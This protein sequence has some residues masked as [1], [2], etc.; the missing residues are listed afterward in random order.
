[1]DA[2]DFKRVL[3]EG[4]ALQARL[5][6]LSPV[7]VGGTAAALHCGHRFSLDV[8]VVAAQLS[9]RFDEVAAQLAEWEGWRTNRLNPPVLILGEHGG[10]ELGVRQ[11]RRAVPLQTTRVSEL[12]VATAAET[13]RIK[14]FL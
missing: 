6:D 4:R 1:M 10:V 5:A 8:D 2:P 13:L 12:L 7:A 9:S 14:A 11:L 3:A